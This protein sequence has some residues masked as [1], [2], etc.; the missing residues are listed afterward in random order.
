MVDVDSVLLS[1]QE[2]DKW[3]R[4]LD[5]L[6]RTYDEVRGQRERVRLRLRR[7]KREL[8][9]LAEYSEAA[10]D[11]RRTLLSTRTIHAASEPVRPPR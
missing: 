2:R 11:A 6:T 5:V 4:R 9:R 7:I 1:L 10:T 8:S 3:R